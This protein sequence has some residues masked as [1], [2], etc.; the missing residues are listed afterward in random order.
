MFRHLFTS[1][2]RLVV[3]YTSLEPSSTP[4]GYWILEHSFGLLENRLGATPQGFES[5][6]L[7]AREA[8]NFNDYRL[9]SILFCEV[10]NGNI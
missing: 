8:C 3:G 4:C 5:L 2:S 9:F 1:A 6:A 10:E 7:R